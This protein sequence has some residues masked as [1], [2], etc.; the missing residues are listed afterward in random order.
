MPILYD[1]N[2]R[3]EVHAEISA[4]I[5]KIRYA[6]EFLRGKKATPKTQDT[7]IMAVTSKG[8]GLV[9]QHFGHASEFLIYRASKDGTVSF[10]GARRVGAY[11]SGIETCGDAEDSLD[12]IINMISDCN[13]LLTSRIGK[14]PHKFVSAAGIEVVQTY[15]S[16]ETAIRTLLERTQGIAL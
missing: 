4:K 15:D 10:I 11:C 14:E 9:T 2:I 16:I 7:L 1:Q 8:D 3:A 13:I 5:E 6:R 12:R